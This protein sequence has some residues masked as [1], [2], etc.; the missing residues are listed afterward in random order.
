MMR[1]E[2]DDTITLAAPG[3]PGTPTCRSVPAV[4]STR[5]CGRCGSRDAPGGGDRPT[6]RPPDR[7]RTRHAGMGCGRSPAS[8]SWLRAAC[9]VSRWHHRRPASRSRTTP[10]AGWP[11]S[12]NWSQPRS[13]TPSHVRLGPAGRRAGGTAANRR[14][15]GPGRAARRDF[16]PSVTRPVACSARTRPSSS[17][18]RRARPWS[19]SASRRPARP[20]S[21]HDGNCR[22]GWPQRSC[23]PPGRLPVSGRRTGRR[24]VG[25]PR[26][27]RVASAWSRR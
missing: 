1:F 10:K 19:L 3:A 18:S 11:V 2:P 6:C 27:P 26:P 21:E 13:P 22:P 7:S 5:S 25:P 15:G 23:I 4:R 24:A 9:G 16:S 17:S 14:A 20:R 8:R 12:P